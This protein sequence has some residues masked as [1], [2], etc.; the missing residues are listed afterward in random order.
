MIELNKIYNEDCL[1]GMKKIPDSSVSLV[2]TDPPYL[3]DNIG[4]GYLFARRQALC[5]RARRYKKWVRP[6][7]F[8]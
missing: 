3:L 8:R 7:G 2:V 6:K 1:N 5:K 4:G